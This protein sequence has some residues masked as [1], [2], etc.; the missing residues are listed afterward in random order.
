[1]D[2]SVGVIT[3]NDPSIAALI[4]Q[5]LSGGVGCH[6]LSEVV[7]VSSGL[8]PENREAVLGLC[9]LHPLLRLVEED[10]RAGKAAAVNR[11]LGIAKGGLCVLVSGDVLLAEDSLTELVRPFSDPKVGM[12]G[13]RVVPLNDDSTFTGYAVNLVWRLHHLVSLNKP[14]VGEAVAFRNVVTCISPTTAVDEAYIEAVLVGMGY[15]V[16]YAPAAV[17]RNMGPRTVSD[18]VRQR[19]R[20]HAGHMMLRREAG[21]SV[22]TLGVLP[23]LA[24]LPGCIDYTPRNIIWAASAA[25]LEAWSRLLACVDV[26]LFGR[27]PYCWGIVESAKIRGVV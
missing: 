9:S 11:F 5:I 10:S 6:H 8:L 1:M 22:S 16:A 15:V 26:Y 18:F 20:I 27:N 17:V 2:V 3:Y 23:L 14:K 19:R 25:A 12:V 13:G 24:L 4:R 21:Y 7:I